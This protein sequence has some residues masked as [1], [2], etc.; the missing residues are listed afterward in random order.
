MKVLAGRRK[1]VALS[2]ISAVAVL[3]TASQ[4]SALKS[5]LTNT[6]VAPG[7]LEVEQTPQAAPEPPV[8][9]ILP[10]TGASDVVP[11]GAVK[12]TATVGTLT[13]VRM[14]NEQGR[15]VAG[16][17]VEGG[18]AWEPAEPLGYGRSYTLSATGRGADASTVTTVSEF[19]TVAPQSQVGVRL[20][21][22]NGAS[23]S[24]GGV[25][26]VGTVIVATF[27]ADIPDRAAAES[28]L[29]VITTPQLAGSWMWINDRKA[30]WRPR[31]YYPSGT[32]VTV[33]ADLYGTAPFLR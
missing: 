1:V 18:R 33:K 32:E 7:A 28:R 29:Q 9:E 31:E 17:L 25:Y 4:T 22:T 16:R 13:D 2:V 8:I 23:L 10:R 27:D 5:R 6:V 24:E 14:Q 11:V 19:S 12:V 30:H 20:G 21:M 3:V 15:V 26:G